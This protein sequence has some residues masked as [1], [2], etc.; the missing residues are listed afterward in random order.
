MSPVYT[1]GG[2]WGECLPYRLLHKGNIMNL[3]WSLEI[4]A[5]ANIDSNYTIFA[6]FEHSP[7]GQCPHAALIGELCLYSDDSYCITFR[8]G[9]GY[10][11][12]DDMNKVVKIID[13]KINPDNWKD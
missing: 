8:D 10:T 2:G 6:I 3:D 4:K 11:C 12:A 9:K 7:P 1:G 5:I 13:K